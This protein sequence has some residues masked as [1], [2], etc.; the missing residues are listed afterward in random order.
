M[1]S[2]VTP[3]NNTTVRLLREKHLEYIQNPQSFPTSKIDWLN[4]METQED[5]SFPDPLH[6]SFQP[7]V[8][9]EIILIRSNGSQ[10]VYRA[11]AGEADITNLLI[12]E[13]YQWFVRIGN[14]QSETYCF[15]TD[16]QAPRMLYVDGISNVRDFGGFLSNTGRRIRQELIYRTSEMDTHVHITEKGIHTLE[17]ELGIRLDIDIR[18]IKNEPRCPILDEEKVRWVNYPLAAYVDC[19]TEEQLK[20]YG[21]SFELLTHEENYPMIIHCWGGIDRTGTW[22]YILGGMLGVSKDDLDLDYEMSS[23]SRWGRRSRVSEQFL[24]FLK[25]LYQYGE[26]LQEACVGFMKAC[27]LT[28]AQLD[29]IKDILLEEAT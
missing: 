13:R 21:E 20:L 4:L 5:K 22:L 23:F 18:G 10:T 11:V 15:E 17:D 1:I 3:Q 29:K 9:G 26:T 19:F 2:L 16:A 24:E 28:D 25:G 12:N 14:E 27:G 7:A 6:F 8:D